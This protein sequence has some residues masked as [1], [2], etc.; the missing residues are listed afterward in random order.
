MTFALAHPR[1]AEVAAPIHAGE[2]LRILAVSPS[3]ER[4][5]LQG[6]KAAIAK[7][8]TD[9]V[10]AT[11]GLTGEVFVSYCGPALNFSASIFRDLPHILQL[12]CSPNE[13]AQRVDELVSLVSS[14]QQQTNQ[15]LRLIV[16]TNCF[17]EKLASSLSPLVDSVV[18][19]FE[20]LPDMTSIVSFSQALYSSILNAKSIH[21][22]VTKAA[23]AA[24]VPYTPR[25]FGIYQGLLGMAGTPRRF[26]LVLTAFVLVS[27]LANP[28]QRKRATAC[29]WYANDGSHDSIQRLGCSARR[30]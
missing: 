5:E 17:T 4:I 2:T 22:A 1:S 15:T 10:L 8:L 7:S 21:A 18:G 16:L 24:G 29:T 23:R 6:L 26:F 14:F 11:I 12:I 27:E 25:I 13:A 20:P 9:S 28:T 3:A 30:P 19:F